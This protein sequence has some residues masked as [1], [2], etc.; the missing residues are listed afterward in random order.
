LPPLGR[1]YAQFDNQGRNR[2]R[3]ESGTIVTAVPPVR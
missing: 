1:R 2:C 3:L